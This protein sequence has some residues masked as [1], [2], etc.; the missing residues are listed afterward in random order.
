[1]LEQICGKF[2]THVNATFSLLNY[3]KKSC[4]ALFSTDVPD[5]Y[6]VETNLGDDNFETLST[7]AESICW[8]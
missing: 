2:M 3:Q 6:L 8:I 4:T 5:I 1:M 7:V